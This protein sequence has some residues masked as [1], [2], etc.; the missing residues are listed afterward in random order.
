MVG[1][2]QAIADCD[3]HPAPR[4][5]EKDI[6][7][8]LAPRWR[9]HI[10]TVGMLARQGFTQ[11][12]QYPKGQ[13]M[14]VRRDA[15]PPG[16]GMPGSD[17][18]FM[19]A[20]HLDPNNV[21]FG[22]LIPLGAAQSLQNID[23]SVALCTAINDW[24]VEEWTSREPRLRG[25]IV[26][27]YQDPQA[28]VAEIH[29]LA[30]K[31][32]FV[33][34]SLLSRLPNPIG[35][36]S[37]WPIYAAAAEVGLPIGVHAFGNGGWAITGGGWPSY[38]GEDMMSHAQTSQSALASLVLEG[39]FERFPTLRVALIEGGLG[40]LPSL[41]W[42][43]DRIWERSRDELAHLPRPPSEYIRESV[44]LTSQP[45]EEPANRQHI[46][47]VIDWIGWDRVLF[48]SDYPHW[49]FDDPQRAMPLPLS[50]ERRDRFFLKNALDL[51]GIPHG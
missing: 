5:M 30:G 32:D 4:S 22:V 28:A 21:Q 47:E 14:A 46:A 15:F 9:T 36:R 34:V 10:A 1:G 16:G 35:H 2:R 31:R 6:F 26:A 27:A 45:I 19:R 29:R 7:S 44:W 33:Q 12:M 25:S 42:R 40:W 49:D 39:V 17:L 23:L 3:I 8:R 37:F 24:Q 48:A 13:P 51:Y 41:R 43:L 50:R 38:Y 18:D 11:E 20:Q